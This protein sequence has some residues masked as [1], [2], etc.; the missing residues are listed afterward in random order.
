M[1][2]GSIHIRG[3]RPLSGRSPRSRAVDPALRW[4]LT[5]LAAAILVL[6]AF[7]FV[8]LYVE[9]KPA[10]D[11]FGHL[12]FTF[13]SNWDVAHA[14]YGA[15]PLLT[16]TLIT[17]A[18]ALLIGVPVAVAA[19]VYVSE[20]APRRLGGALSTLIELLAAVPSVV[21]GLWGVSS[22]RRRGSRTRSRSCRSSATRSR[23]RT[24]SSAG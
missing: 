9:A 23:A 17:A 10:F 20:L 4:A 19:A 14:T 18:I 11:R 5:G 22:P 8:R 1:E 15:L 24:C 6:I 12:G 7:F 13:D 2:A 16:G 21:Y 3:G